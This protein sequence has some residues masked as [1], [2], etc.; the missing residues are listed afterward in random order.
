VSLKFL[1]AWGVRFFT[2]DNFFRLAETEVVHRSERWLKLP[3]LRK[4]KQGKDLP[5]LVKKIHL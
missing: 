3:S 2:G 4:R 5:P 1:A